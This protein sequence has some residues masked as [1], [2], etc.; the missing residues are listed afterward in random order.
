MEMKKQPMR[1]LSDLFVPWLENY[2]GACNPVIARN[3]SVFVFTLKH[4]E[5]PTIYTVLTRQ[6]VYGENLRISHPSIGAIQLYSNSISGDGR[7]LILFMDDGDD[8]NL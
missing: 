4:R 3:D 5:K 6:M 1:I 7:M 8:G 2:P